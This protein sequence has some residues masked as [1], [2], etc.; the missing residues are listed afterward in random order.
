AGFVV[1]R[2]GETGQEMVLRPIAHLRPD[3]SNQ[4]I[5]V[6]AIKAFQ[7]IIGPC[8]QQGKDGAI[9]VGAPDA[10]EPQYCLV[11]LLRSEANIVAVA[12]VI[13]RARDVERARQRLT[14]MQLVAGYFELFQLR[15]GA[16][17]A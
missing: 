16:I 8:V 3:D 4:E 11:T 9:E 2:G 5:R 6:A 14:S 15:R 17:E 10:G 13:T 7:E 1:E 12:A